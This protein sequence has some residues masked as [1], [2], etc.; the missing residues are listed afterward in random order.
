MTLQQIRTA[1]VVPGPRIA[2]PT[3][4]APVA[5]T[6]TWQY[7]PGARPCV[8]YWDVEAA[9]WRSCSPA[10]GPRVAD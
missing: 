6:E 7:R 9:R 2:E 8:E 5:W 1:G 4:A 10:P 3:V